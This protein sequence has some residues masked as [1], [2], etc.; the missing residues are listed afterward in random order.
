MMWIHVIALVALSAG[1]ESL[2]LH[3]G[4]N[5]IDEGWPL[6]AA[7]RL[8]EGGVLYQDTFFVFPPGHLLASWLAYA[9][10]PPG[11]ILARIISAGFNVSLVV[12]LY[13][14][15]R[16]L[17]PPVV[18]L[19]GCAM[20]AVA[21]PDSHGAHYL[22]G[23]RYLLWSA[24]AMLCFAQRL[25][26]GDRRWMIAAGVFAGINLVFRLSPAPAVIAGIVVGIAAA[27]RDWR[28]WWA[29]ASRL[30]LGFA[31]VVLPVA[32]WLAASAGWESIWREVIV[33]PLSMTDLQS[34]TVPAL[35]LPTRWNRWEI[36]TF[37]VNFQFRL[38]VVMY[39][40]YAA[41]LGWQLIRALK[42]RQP[43]RSPLLLAVVAWGGIFFL[44][45]FGR[46]DEA[47]LDSALPVQCLLL[48]YAVGIPLKDA[49]NRPGLARGLASACLIAFFSIWVFL[50]ASDRYVTDPSPVRRSVRSLDSETAVSPKERLRVFDRL[51][52]QMRAKAAP[53]E[54]VLDLSSS[55]LLHV[56][57]QRS[58]PGWADVVQPGSFLSPVEEHAFVSVLEASPPV[59]VIMPLW[60]YDNMPSRAIAKFAPELVRWVLER[61]EVYLR[62]GDFVLMRPKDDGGRNRGDP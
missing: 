9:W 62:L 50:I 57:S 49:L 31:V 45:S 27:E 15:G 59:L 17:M 14:L 53:G 24:L 22:F 39:A 3:R 61:Y 12:A 10:S 51:V 41:V 37:F 43:F 44:R 58:G 55:P 11:V 35:E 46:A 6:Y 56:V 36:R 8:H 13:F 28:S 40:G 21:A 25:Q 29:D 60:N 47:H 18:A 30:A 5:A 48:A 23:Y 20:L 38:Y 4:L 32:V 54:V 1:F 7:M 33:R 19:L 42:A 26:D 16:R 52:G 2:F 34:F